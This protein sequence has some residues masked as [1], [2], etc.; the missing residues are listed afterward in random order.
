MRKDRLERDMKNQ[1]VDSSAVIQ[2]LD[3]WK[4]DFRRANFQEFSGE[5][6][7]EHLRMTQQLAS[8][9]RGAMGRFAGR[10]EQKEIL[11][12]YGMTQEEYDKFHKDNAIEEFMLMNPGDIDVPDEGPVISVPYEGKEEAR[13]QTYKLAKNYISIDDFTTSQGTPVSQ[14]G[15]G[16]MKDWFRGEYL[17][18]RKVSGSVSTIKP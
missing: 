9:R 6:V 17:Q 13:G 7:S 5:Y 4:K 18:G 1:G 8:M 15:E 12:E 16:A 2:N 11:D 14:L 10:R 3:N